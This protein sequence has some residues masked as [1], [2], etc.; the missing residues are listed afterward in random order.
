MT[1]LDLTHADALVAEAYRAHASGDFSSTLEL[2]DRLLRS[3]PTHLEALLLRSMV[4]NDMNRPEDAA[5][6]A[7]EALAVDPESATAHLM[8]ARAFDA[9]RR[10]SSAAQDY[11]F[12]AE[13]FSG[14]VEAAFVWLDSCRCALLAGDEHGAKQAVRRAYAHAVAL[15]RLIL[16]DDLELLDASPRLDE[17]RS[18]PLLASKV[19]G[20]LT[21]VC[22]RWPS[23]EM[24][25]LAAQVSELSHRLLTV[26]F[27][28]GEPVVD[29]RLADQVRVELKLADVS[30]AL[31]LDRP[32]DAL[33]LA[34]SLVGMAP[35]L[36]ASWVALSRAQSANGLIEEADA[37]VDHATSLSHRPEFGNE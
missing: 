13:A 17:L 14:T 12:V 8:R 28:T 4:L 1:H 16:D 33:S 10:F 36:P 15:R 31:L 18:L 19:V 29:P 3:W 6:A 21:Q 27:P 11:R 22:L 24:V 2:S 23:D 32:T 5:A 7:S 20:F 35:D 9:I 34:E 25:A 30:I 37:S 26:K